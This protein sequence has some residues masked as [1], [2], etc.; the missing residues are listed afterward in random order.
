MARENFEARLS[1]AARQRQIGGRK[2][3]AAHLSMRGAV[4]QSYE[5]IRT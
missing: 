4:Y 2:E 1:H 3:N 5:R